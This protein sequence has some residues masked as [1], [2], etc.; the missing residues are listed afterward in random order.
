MAFA[1]GK[2]FKKT[3]IC[4]LY[5]ANDIDAASNFIAPRQ[6]RPEIPLCMGTAKQTCHHHVGGKAWLNHM[7]CP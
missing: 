2:A 7:R 5:L 4:A 3:R 6:N 1:D